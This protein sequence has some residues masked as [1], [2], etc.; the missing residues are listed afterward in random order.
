MQFGK[1]AQQRMHPLAWNQPARKEKPAGL[2]LPDRELD[3]VPSPDLN[4]SLRVGEFAA[5]VAA[6]CERVSPGGGRSAW[7]TTA[8][9]PQRLNGSGGS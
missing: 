5:A 2:T 4:G 1:G 3:R 6:A 7:P 8:A 9:D